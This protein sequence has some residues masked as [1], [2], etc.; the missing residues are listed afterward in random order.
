MPSDAERIADHT[1]FSLAEAELL[2]RNRTLSGDPEEDHWSPHVIVTPSEV[3]LKHPET[4]S[5]HPN[6]PTAVEI[7]ES[8]GQKVEIIRRGQRAFSESATSDEEVSEE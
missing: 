3:V 5:R 4:T 1:H 2:L 6:I 7:A 8:T